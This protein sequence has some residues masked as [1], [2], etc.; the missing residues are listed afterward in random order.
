MI[1][2][3][4]R[5][6]RIIFKKTRFYDFYKRQ[7]ARLESYLFYLGFLKYLLLVKSGKEDHLS[8]HFK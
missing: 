6:I 5:N 8:T 1:F 2:E 3:V 7:K 4:V